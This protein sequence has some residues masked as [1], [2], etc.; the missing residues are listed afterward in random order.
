MDGWYD[1]DKFSAEE[2]KVV[3]LF[4]RFLGS[5][6]GDICRMRRKDALTHPAVFFNRI[7]VRGTNLCSYVEIN[8]P[9]QCLNAYSS[10]LRDPVAC[11]LS[12]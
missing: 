10:F 8:L 12:G 5:A 3:D 11:N 9:F 1:L 6:R 4:F 2:S 7:L